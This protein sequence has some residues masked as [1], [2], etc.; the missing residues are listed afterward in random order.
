[1]IEMQFILYLVKNGIPFEIASRLS[2][3][4]T[5]AIAKIISSLDK[6]HETAPDSFP[7][8]AFHER[9]VRYRPLTGGVFYCDLLK[10]ELLDDKLMPLKP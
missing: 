4:E 6:A 7:V 8:T 1:M 9:F 5:S 10:N 3:Q 2:A